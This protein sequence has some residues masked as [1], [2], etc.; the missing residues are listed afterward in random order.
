MNQYH[1]GI[2]SNWRKWRLELD[3]LSERPIP[4]CYCPP[5]KHLVH[6]ELHGF[7]HTS[8]K[9]YSGVV[10]IHVTDSK[11]GPYSSIVLAKTKVAPIHRLTIPQLELCGASLV[12]SSTTCHDS[13]RHIYRSHLSMD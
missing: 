7:C 13:T 12:P 2:I 3:E 6:R 5:D 4:R 1:D 11:G 10:Y 9:A 8:E